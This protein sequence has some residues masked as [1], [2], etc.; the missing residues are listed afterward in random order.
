MQNL[1]KVV[2]LKQEK[3]NKL[4]ENILLKAYRRSCGKL[5]LL[6]VIYSQWI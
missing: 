4:K 5:K 3:V 1:D 6:L 2:Y